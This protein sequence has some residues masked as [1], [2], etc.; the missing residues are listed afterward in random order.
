MNDL[1]GGRIEVMFDTATVSMNQIRGGTIRA[2]GVSTKERIPALP[3][4]APIAD[5]VSGFDVG[6]WFALYYPGKTPRN[7]VESVAA[8]VRAVLQQDTAKTLLGELGARIVASTP[9]ELA[10]H[11]R[12]ET[13]RWGIVIR[14][15]GIKAEGG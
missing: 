11:M 9:D 7:I 14:E 10:A 13:E 1:I 8:D 12:A 6:S 4:V 2:L 15:A 5:T 3:E